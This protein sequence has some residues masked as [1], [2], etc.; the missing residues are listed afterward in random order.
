MNE[1]Q[2]AV[3]WE[4]IRILDSQGVLPDLILIGSWVEYIYAE[5]NY[6]SGF[7]PNIRTIDLD[8]LIPNIRRP[9]KKVPLC[10]VMER[11]GFMTQQRNDGLIKFSNFEGPLE[12]EF[13]VRD[14]GQGQIEPYTVEGLG[15][16]AAGLRHLDILIQWTTTLFIR[17]YQLL[18]PL[19]EAYV[20]HKL[21]INNKRLQGMK[22]KKDLMSI[23]E[24]LPFIK[25]SGQNLAK[26]KEI[27][28]NGL[29]RNE[30]AL[31]DTTC[32]ANLIR[33]FN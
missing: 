18:V 31:V 12:V 23:E 14:M 24:L 27:Y 13:L 28:D 4:T 1:K 15:I 22:Q 21:V 17:L 2:E 3:F 16:K 19:P 10:D 7:Q 11:H 30:R 32:K 9:A 25:S 33:L 8:F 5:S 26:L 20:L 29:T 6:F